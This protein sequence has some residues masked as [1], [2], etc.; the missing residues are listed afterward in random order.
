MNYHMIRTDDMLNGD[1]LRVVVFLAMCDHHCLGCH[2]PETWNGYGSKLFDE[3]AKN[4][5]YAELDKD[6]ISGITLSGGDPLNEANIDDVLELI[7]DIRI[8][9]PNKTVW[10]YTGFSWEQIVSNIKLYNI[11]RLCDVVVDGRFIQELADVNYPW[12]GSTN[13]RVIDI[14]KTIANQ[15]LTLLNN[16]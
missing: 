6:Y 12:A 7:K 1:G 14:N 9:Y 2:N 5:V 8:K 4:M 16:S 13:Q 15:R 10:L 11:A 3:E